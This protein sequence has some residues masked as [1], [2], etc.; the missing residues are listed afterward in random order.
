MMETNGWDL[1]DHGE[2]VDETGLG[3]CVYKRRRR[4]IEWCEDIIDGI[5]ED[6][7]S[8]N[9]VMYKADSMN[10]MNDTQAQYTSTL[11]SFSST[12]QQQH[13]VHLK[14]SSS[15][16][17]LVGGF[18]SQLVLFPLGSL[19]FPPFLSSKCYPPVFCSFMYL[20]VASF[21]IGSLP[22]SFASSLPL[23]FLNPR[24]M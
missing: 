13:Q 12:T 16:Y 15:T 6:S 5:M 21:Q 2:V 9:V 23:F 22:F 3:S 10:Q 7:N 4:R 20:E 1:V 11:Y 14:H 18:T 19:A 8:S 24:A 17:L